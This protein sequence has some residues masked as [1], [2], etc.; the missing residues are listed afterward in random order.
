MITTTIER[1]TEAD[2]D[3]LMRFRK[4]VTSEGKFV[5]FP[6]DSRKKMEENQ[7]FFSTHEHRHFALKEGEKI[8]GLAYYSLGPEFGIATLQTIV[9]LKSDA[10]KGFGHALLS[11]VVRDCKK[12]E[13]TLLNAEVAVSNEVCLE[14]C[15]RNGFYS[16]KRRF[17]TLILRKKL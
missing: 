7:K 13:M 8:I 11:A 10:G 4:Q 15:K 5:R 17:K 3:E 14:F 12:E 1:L 9:V 6:N 2:Y 16:F